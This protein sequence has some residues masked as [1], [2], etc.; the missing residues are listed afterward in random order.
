V[1][2]ANPKLQIQCLAKRYEVGVLEDLSLDVQA[3]ELLCLL[4]P[5]GSGKT[6]LLRILAG[7]ETPDTGTVAIDGRPV[8][9]QARRVGMVFQEPRLL[10]W[11]TVRDNI[12]L[13]L[14]PVQV[15]GIEASARA[16]AYL[17]LV[18]LHG[19]EAY[20]PSRLSG[21]M[22]QRASIARALAVEPELLLMDEPFSAL[23]AEHRRQLQDSL[24]DIWQTTR[25]TIIFVTH[26]I[27]EA[28][29][30]GSRVVLLAGRPAH[31]CRDYALASTSDR[32][33]LADELLIELSA[34][35]RGQRARD[36]ERSRDGSAF[37]RR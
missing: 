31:V 15:V 32:V 10:G 30:I 18:G 11:K 17:G 27:D 2:S 19:F 26:S 6:T 5:N 33:A 16:N 4:G 8:A 37:G 28:L 35:A 9:A 21:G 23:D 13:C 22:Q 25:Q 36:L 24:V 14:K 34:Q 1:S 12:R 29:R 7:L 20:Y 3:G